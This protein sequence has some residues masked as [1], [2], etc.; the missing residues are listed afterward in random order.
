MDRFISQKGILKLMG[1]DTNKTYS[2]KETLKSFFQGQRDPLKSMNE[3]ILDE[4]TFDKLRPH[5]TEY[6]VSDFALSEIL[7]KVRK[8]VR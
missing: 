5:W 1:I 6:D 8:I 3:K 2:Q 4:L 7:I